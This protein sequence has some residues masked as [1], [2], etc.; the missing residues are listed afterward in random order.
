MQ[1]SDMGWKFSSPKG[2][3]E[4]I[5]DGRNCKFIVVQIREEAD[6]KSKG[7]KAGYNVMSE[8]R[9]KKKNPLGTQ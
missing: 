1:N 8:R 6:R 2:I 5:E 3:Q 4:V 7:Y 9:S